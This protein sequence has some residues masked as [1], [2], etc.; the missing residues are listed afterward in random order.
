MDT[1]GINEKL[2]KIRQRLSEI[3]L[4]KLY[5]LIIETK[6]SEQDLLY[7]IYMAVRCIEPYER[8]YPNSDS[9]LEN[10]MIDELVDWMDGKRAAPIYVQV[11]I[12]DHNLGR[13]LRFRVR[14]LLQ[15]IFS[16]CIVRL[17][18]SAPEVLNESVVEKLR[19]MGIL[20]AVAKDMLLWSS[21]LTR[22]GN[23]EFFESLL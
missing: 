7:V 14:S 2:E 17:R 23:R 9:S 10:H 16:H 22:E 1:L 6:L 5:E 19:S 21:H 15:N 11:L 8:I 12:D 4:E 3:A 13:P 20:Q 18:K